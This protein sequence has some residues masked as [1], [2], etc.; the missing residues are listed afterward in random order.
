MNLAL[1]KDIGNA[2]RSINEMP[3]ARVAILQ[4]EGKIFTAGLDLKEASSLL[5]PSGE[6]GKFEVIQMW[7][8]A[9]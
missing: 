8:E 5:G 2:F 1:F 6:E 3:N 9:P 4:A 7:P